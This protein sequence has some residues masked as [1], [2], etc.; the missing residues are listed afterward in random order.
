MTGKWFA[1][2]DPR[3]RT[4]LYVVLALGALLALI[5]GTKFGFQAGLSVA[6]GAGAAAANLYA[7]AKIIRA[8]TTPGATR[9][10]A[11][12]SIAFALKLVFL[13]G[14]LWLLLTWGVVS[15][16][17]LLIGYGTLPIGIAISSLVSDKADDGSSED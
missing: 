16:L 3:L 8:L 11:G 9:S 14:G 17:P 2:L 7:L 6:I 10:V 13:V 5:G 15:T 4:T 1:D 12:W